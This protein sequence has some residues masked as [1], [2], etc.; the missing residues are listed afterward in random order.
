VRLRPTVRLRL[1]LVYGG[2]FLAAGT[3]LLL[4]NYGLVRRNLP[5]PTFQEIVPAD[6]GVEVTLPTFRP[7]EAPHRDIDRALREEAERFRQATLNELVVQ[8]AIALGIMAVASV[9]LGWLV[10]GR[11]LQPLKDITTT[12]RRLSEENL[13]ERIG[14]SGPPDEL[15]ELADTFDAMLARLE[16]AFDAQRRFI[17]NASHELRTP[18]AIEQTMLEVALADPDPTVEKLQAVAEKVYGVSRRNQRL[19]ESLLLL[20][21]SAREVE[22][23]EAVDLAAALDDAIAQLRAEIEQRRLGFTTELE[24][25]WTAGDRPLLERTVAN[26]LEN[27]VRHNLEGGWVRVSS[28]AEE[29]RVR[30]Q[31]VNSGPRLPAEAVDT[32][33][34]PFR[35]FSAD[36][37]G[38]DRGVGLGLSI[39]KTVVATHGGDIS[40]LVLEEGGLMVEVTLPGSP[41]E[42]RA[43][44]VPSEA[45]EVLGRD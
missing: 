35:R 9:A 11:V 7:D 37:T 30:I 28:G 10:A 17:A 29:G 36:R 14:L 34:E 6:P 22:E 5:M 27:A 19:I 42:A 39:A 31:V 13:H 26:L 25:A 15:K 32:L 1:T 24:P 12:A 44:Q 33:F 41:A 3:V 23:P 45:L 38:S 4:V 18:L 43:G 40:A 16:A 8:S 21:R 2:L 20:A